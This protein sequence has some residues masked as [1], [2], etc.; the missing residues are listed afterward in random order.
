MPD[1]GTLESHE[2]DEGEER[3]VPVIVEQPETDTE[4]LEDKERRD[5]MLLP[6]L[7]EAW[8]RNVESIISVM[9]SN[10]LQLILTGQ[11]T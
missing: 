7:G 5:G 6:Q 8:H 3:V 4:D 2:H 10:L 11:T 9:L 1:H